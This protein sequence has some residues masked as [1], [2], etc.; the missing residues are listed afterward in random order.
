MTRS[1][2]PLAPPIIHRYEGYHVSLHWTV[3][4]LERQVI[5]SSLPN[6]IGSAPTVAGA[7]DDFLAPIENRAW[8]LFLSLD[9]Q[10]YAAVYQ[11][12]SIS[13]FTVP[14]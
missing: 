1:P 14:R 2:L 3:V 12:S 11:G 4:P 5:V 6:V 9:Q 13:G 8:D 10:Q 7:D